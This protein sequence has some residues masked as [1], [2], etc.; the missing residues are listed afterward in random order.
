MGA[1]RSQLIIN[2]GMTSALR[3]I[4]KAM[5]L[6]IGN[7]EAIQRASGQSIN[8]ANLNA[9]R[10]E[11]GKANAQLDVMQQNYICKSKLE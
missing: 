2:D 6:M 3:R 10:Q 5:S 4:N 7:F 9:A 8:A 1:V 11:I